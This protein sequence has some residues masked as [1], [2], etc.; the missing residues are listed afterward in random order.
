[1]EERPF[2]CPLLFVWRTCL[3]E[4]E[5]TALGVM[6]VDWRECLNIVNENEGDRSNGLVFIKMRSW[7][8]NELGMNKRLGWEMSEVVGRCHGVTHHC[9]PKESWQ[10]IGSE[11]KPRNVPSLDIDDKPSKHG[12]NDDFPCF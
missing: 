6:V 11:S 1:M 12:P 10:T 4:V 8:F 7:A 9:E 2:W 3:D 5:F